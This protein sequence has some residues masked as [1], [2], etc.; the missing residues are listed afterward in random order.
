[1]KW[2]GKGNDPSQERGQTQSRGSVGWGGVKTPPSHT[3]ASTSP[4]PLVLHD[5]ILLM[6]ASTIPW[7]IS[8]YSPDPGNLGT[9]LGDAMLPHMLSRNQGSKFSLR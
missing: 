6:S 4:S 9:G 3:Q 5:P 2:N 7:K 1:M 8:I